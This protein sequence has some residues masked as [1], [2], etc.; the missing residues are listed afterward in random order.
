MIS[1]AAAAA[2][3]RAPDLT[4][5]FTPLS[6]DA[7][8]ALA[9]PVPPALQ[10]LASSSSALAHDVQQMLAFANAIVADDEGCTILWLQVRTASPLPRPLLLLLLLRIFVFEA[11]SPPP[12]HPLCPRHRC[13]LSSLFSAPP[14]VS[15]LVAAGVSAA[16]S[17]LGG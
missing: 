14:K 17:F 11:R 3:A 13:A 1:P 9:G 8:A 2:E 4:P 10:E 7:I 16:G 15:P 5:Q 12:R 6:A